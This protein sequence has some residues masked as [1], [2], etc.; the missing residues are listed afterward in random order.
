MNNCYES[1]LYDESHSRVDSDDS[2][3]I[4]G[5]PLGFINWLKRLKRLT[6]LRLLGMVGVCTY[7]PINKVNSKHENIIY[8]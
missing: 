3:A 1:G 7:A 5:S 2:V 4:I 6:L 8:K